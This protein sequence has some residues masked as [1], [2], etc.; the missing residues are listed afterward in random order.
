MAINESLVIVEFIADLYPSTKLVPKV[1]VQKAKASMFARLMDSTVLPA[2]QDCIFSGK[3][4]ITELYAVFDLVQSQ[5]P[6]GVRYAV[7]DDFTIADIA[8]ASF[9]CLL[10]MMLKNDIGKYEKGDGL[11]A[12]EVYNSSKYDKLRNYVGRLSER[13]SVKKGIQLVSECYLIVSDPDVLIPIQD[14][15]KETFG[16]RLARES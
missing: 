1:P 12:F 7:G 6:D 16:K 8:A 4:D 2:L 5:L 15:V 3:K 14:I 11:K 10:E 13:P 9:F